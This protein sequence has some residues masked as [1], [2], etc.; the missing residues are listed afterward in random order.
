MSLERTEADRYD[1]HAAEV[2]RSVSGAVVSSPIRS[3]VP[4]SVRHT[5]VT[6]WITTQVDSNQES[7]FELRDLAAA[8]HREEPPCP[9]TPQ[10]P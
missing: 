4:S 10:D 7:T 1:G 8:S 9:T 5:V 2:G 3:M 6:T